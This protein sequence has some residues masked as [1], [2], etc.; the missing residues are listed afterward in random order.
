MS[1]V[2]IDSEICTG[3]KDCLKVCK[4]KVFGWEKAKKVKFLTKIKLIIESN[5]YQAFVKNE[6]NCTTCMDCVYACPE[7]AITVN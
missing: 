7:G 5:G 2:E 3:K 1:K 4:E 6:K